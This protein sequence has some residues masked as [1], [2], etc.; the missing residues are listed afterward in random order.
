MRLSV[1]IDHVATLRQA[2]RAKE[3]DP[4]AAAVMA[5]L[6]GAHGLTVHLRGDRRHIQERDLY[7]LKEATRL[8]L[9]VEIALTPEGL[10]ICREAGVD[11]AT[12]VPENP[13]EVTTE[14]GIDVAGRRAEVGEYTRLYR[15]AGIQVS[16]FIDPDPKQVKAAVKLKPDFVEFNTL[17]YGAAKEGAARERALARVSAAARI[18]VRHGIEVHA[19]HDINYLNARPLVEAVPEIREASIGHAIIARAVLVGLERATREMLEA[20]GGPG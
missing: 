7:I 2:R 18:A 17:E 9:N 3:P 11:Q 14:G 12:L 6:G 4:V 15:E 1:N 5:Q 19:G 8:K 16:Y 10:K 20:L 13:D